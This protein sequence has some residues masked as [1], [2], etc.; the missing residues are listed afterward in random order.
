MSDHSDFNDLAVVVGN[1]AVLETITKAVDKHHAGQRSEP[2]S[3]L[4][5][6]K[7]SSVQPEHSLA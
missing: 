7:A 6:I 3:R 2:Y 5:L 1:N 4:K